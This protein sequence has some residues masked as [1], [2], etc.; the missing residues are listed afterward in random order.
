MRTVQRSARLP[1]LAPLVGGACL[2]ARVGV[3]HD[4]GVQPGT[5]AVVGI[6]AREVGI[7]EFNTGDSAVLER[8]AQGGD[9]GFDTSHPV[10]A[11]NP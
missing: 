10:I 1:P 9:I 2:L 11:N 3:E 6:D 5:V 4:D 8:A 7:D